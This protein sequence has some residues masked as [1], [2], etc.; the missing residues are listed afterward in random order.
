M[1][2]CMTS[3][4]RVGALGQALVVTHSLGCPL[5]EGELLRATQNHYND[6]KLT[7]TS[8]SMFVDTILQLMTM[9]PPE[10]TLFS[11]G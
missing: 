10:P 11:N 3:G 6:H 7:M 2:N 5:C 1:R 8:S 4:E 9:I